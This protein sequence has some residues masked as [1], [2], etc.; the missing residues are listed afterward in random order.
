MGGK[1]FAQGFGH[2]GHGGKITASVPPQPGPYLGC[3]EP[4]FTR[5]GQ[6]VLEFRKGEIQDIGY[7]IFS[8]SL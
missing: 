5:V 6:P 8:F 4:W 7:W 1:A 3:P 2:V